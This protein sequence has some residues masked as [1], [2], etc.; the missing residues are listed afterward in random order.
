[1]RTLNALNAVA[2]GIAATYLKDGVGTVILEKYQ[3]ADSRNKERQVQPEPVNS[4]LARRLLRYAHVTPSRK[5]VEATA[6]SLHWSFGVLGGLAYALAREHVPVV[7]KTLGQP[8]AMGML[9]IDE[10]AFPAIGAAAPPSRYPAWTHVRAL[11]SHV[12]FGL[13]VAV[14]Y[15]GLDKILNGHTSD[16]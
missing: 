1:M 13:G 15:E 14:M 8:V 16:G 12:T 6:A 2:A 11:V 9:M 3:S 4:I 10:F 7:Q 5:A